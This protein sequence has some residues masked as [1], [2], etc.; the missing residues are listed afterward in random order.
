MHL[1][2]DQSPI[3]H[4]QKKYHHQDEKEIQTKDVIPN[5]ITGQVIPKKGR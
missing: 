3:F 2:E 4:P 5:N 1:K